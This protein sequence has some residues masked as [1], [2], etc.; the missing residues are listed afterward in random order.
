[1]TKTKNVLVAVLSGTIAFAYLFYFINSIISIVDAISSSMSG[2][3]L[4]AFLVSVAALL[5]AIC[6]VVFLIKA[7]IGS[8]KGEAS[9]LSTFTLGLALVAFEKVVSVFGAL[10][11]LIVNYPSAEMGAR[12]IVMCAFLIISLV[13]FVVTTFLA[14]G[15]SKGA[16]GIVGS[17]GSIFFLIV[18][19]MSFSGSSAALSIIY[20]VVLLVAF[21]GVFGYFVLHTVSDFLVSQTISPMPKEE[22]VEEV[23]VNN[24]FDKTNAE[25]GL[26]RLKRLLDQGAITEEEY[27]EKRKQYVDSL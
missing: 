4:A 17:T 26:L 15:K 19:F 10:I 25:Q 24:P 3:L 6:A 14:K 23:I 12:G 2:P 11:I 7:M 21:I 27:E 9:A 16:T 1:M 13:L 18:L 22:K 5:I 20:M 8:I